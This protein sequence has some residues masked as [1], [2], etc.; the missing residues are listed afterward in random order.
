MTELDDRE[1]GGRFLSGRGDDAMDPG[2]HD[3]VRDAFEHHAGIEDRVARG[4]DDVA[5]AVRSSHLQA[6]R[7][8]TR[9]RRHEID[10]AVFCRPDVRAIGCVGHGRVVNGAREV[11]AMLGHGI[12]KVRRGAETFRDDAQE[13]AL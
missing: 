4:R 6:R 3:A 2:G 12:E 10:V 13:A 5:P 1:P 7:R 8:G 11:R 9:E